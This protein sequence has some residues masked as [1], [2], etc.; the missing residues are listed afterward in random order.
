MKTLIENYKKP[1]PPKWRKIGDFAL[2]MIPAM[3]VSVMNLEIEPGLQKL[4]V[5][6]LSLTLVAIKFWTNT[7]I[8]EN[9][10]KGKL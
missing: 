10:Y 4:I 1:T 6:C 3:V 9:H 5:E 2:V 7:K 8:D